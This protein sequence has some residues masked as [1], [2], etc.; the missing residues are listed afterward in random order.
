MRRSLAHILH[1]I[2]VLLFVLGPSSD[3]LGGSP[4]RAARVAAPSTA[5]DPAAPRQDVPGAHGRPQG[6]STTKQDGFDFAAQL[7]RDVSK[8]NGGKVPV[9]MPARSFRQEQGAA[10]SV[11]G[12]EFQGE[13]AF[14]RLERHS[15]VVHARLTETPMDIVVAVDKGSSTGGLTAE[16]LGRIGPAIEQSRGMPVEIRYEQAEWWLIMTN[17]T[18]VSLKVPDQAMIVPPT[19]QDST[20]QL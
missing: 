5:T 2:V 20:V 1:V 10:T 16:E 12:I 8:R 7:A 3:V 11:A 19:E 14:A 9:V 6:Q 18:S 15:G 17:G 13:R 4:S